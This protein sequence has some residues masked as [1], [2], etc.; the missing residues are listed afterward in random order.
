MIME[1]AALSISVTHKPGCS[2]VGVCDV[3]GSPASK[4]IKM[5]I[6]VSFCFLICCLKL[7][8]L[9]VV[10]VVLV[11][12][13]LRRQILVTF[14]LVPQVDHPLNFQRNGAAHVWLSIKHGLLLID[15]VLQAAADEYFCELQQIWT[16]FTDSGQRL[17]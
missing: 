14:G 17:W 6:E 7:T 1:K 2:T 8:F 10:L 13:V 11:V 15:L 3:G 4:R 5:L 12:L 16:R 9:L